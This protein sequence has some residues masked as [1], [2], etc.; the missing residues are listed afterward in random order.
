MRPEF[1]VVI[2]NIKRKKVKKRKEKVSEMSKGG[3]NITVV[4]NDI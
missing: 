4:N 3:E 1:D 2:R